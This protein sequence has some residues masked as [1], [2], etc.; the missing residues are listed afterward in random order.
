[1]EKSRKEKELRM[2]EPETFF[3][4]GDSTFPKDQARFSPEHRFT[5]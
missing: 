2:F 1:M 5:Y 4:F 3:S